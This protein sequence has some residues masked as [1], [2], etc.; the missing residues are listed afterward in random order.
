VLRQ[1]GAA[2]ICR[3][4]FET[5]QSASVELHNQLNPGLGP[6][7]PS[8]T[9]PRSSTPSATTARARIPRSSR[10]SPYRLRCIARCSFD[11][12][13]VAS[14]PA[15]RPQPQQ[16]ARAASLRSCSR[17]WRCSCSAPAVA[18]LQLAEFLRYGCMRKQGG[19]DRGHGTE[20]EE[21]GYRQETRGRFPQITARMQNSLT[22]YAHEE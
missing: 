18:A 11:S 2:R 3:P 10:L 17:N 6:V 12:T 16:T 20:E 8:S 4:S 7:H 21:S 13:P 19:F 22:G 1:L 15:I 9:S 5:F 14:F